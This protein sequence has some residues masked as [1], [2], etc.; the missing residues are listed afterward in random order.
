MKAD[1]VAAALPDWFWNWTRKALRIDGAVK[2]WAEFVI[3]PFVDRRIL[4]FVVRVFCFHTHRR[5]QLSLYSLQIMTCKGYVT[6][7][8]GSGSCPFR[9]SYFLRAQLGWS[10]RDR[11]VEVDISGAARAEC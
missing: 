6:H 11:L 3:V 2:W 5:H 9:K 8:P 4:S 10:G 7:S 1:Y